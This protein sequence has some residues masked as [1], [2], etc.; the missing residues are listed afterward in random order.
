MARK[1]RPSFRGGSEK[2]PEYKELTDLHQDNYAI[3]AID[4]SG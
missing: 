4:I 2:A 3:D 1:A